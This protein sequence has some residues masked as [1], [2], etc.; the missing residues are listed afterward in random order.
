MGVPTDLHTV[1]RVPPLITTLCAIAIA[2][3]LSG[4]RCPGEAVEAALPKVSS[5]L[6]WVGDVA[7][8]GGTLSEVAHG[9]GTAS[10]NGTAIKGQLEKI[11]AS[12][13]PYGEALVAATCYGLTNLAAQYDENNDVLPASA[14]SWESFLNEQLPQQLPFKP[15]EEINTRVSQFNTAA[16]LASISPSAARTVSECVIRRG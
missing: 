15:I 1:R 7:S 2:G 9:L 13:D 4:A 8:S 3:T 14:E 5:S 12:D 16:Q 11:A 10:D 6:H